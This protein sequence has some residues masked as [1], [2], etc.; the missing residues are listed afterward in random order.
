MPAMTLGIRN[1]AM[2][3]IDKDLA[4]KEFISYGKG[5]VETGL[6]GKIL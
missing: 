2:S 6:D 5:V 3:K 1:I 4:L